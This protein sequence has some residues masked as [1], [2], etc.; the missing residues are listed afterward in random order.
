MSRGR[1]WG[2]YIYMSL[3]LSYL[4][5]ISC[6]VFVYNFLRF[7]FRSFFFLNIDMNVNLCIYLNQGLELSRFHLVHLIRQ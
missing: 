4:V 5:Y 7:S 6:L 3:H 2:L 1:I